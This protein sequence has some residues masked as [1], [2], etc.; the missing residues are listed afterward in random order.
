[1]FAGQLARSKYGRRMS[2]S[3]LRSEPR[4]ESARLLS[5]EE[6]PSVWGVFGI[7]QALDF[8]AVEALISNLKPGAEGFGRAQ[9]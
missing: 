8:T 2:V 3:T 9:V 4:D 6:A 1:M 5:S 7:I